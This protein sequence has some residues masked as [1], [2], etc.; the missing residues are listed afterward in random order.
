MIP[1]R[2]SHAISSYVKDRIETGSFLRSVLENNL[3]RAVH[4]ADPWAVGHLPHIVAYVT[5]NVPIA[6]WGSEEKVRSWLENAPTG[7]G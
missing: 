5:D 6:A 4:L 7:T 3:F 2:Y 1:E